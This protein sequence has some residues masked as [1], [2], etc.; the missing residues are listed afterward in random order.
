MAST[1]ASCTVGLNVEVGKR[2]MALRGS[3]EDSLTP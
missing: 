2:N 3:E 1:T